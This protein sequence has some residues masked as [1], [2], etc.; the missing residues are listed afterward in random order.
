MLS[1]WAR[2]MLMG[3][4]RKHQPGKAAGESTSLGFMC[5]GHGQQKTHA[6]DNIAIQSPAA[7]DGAGLDHLVNHL[8]GSKRGCRA[9]E[10]GAAGPLLVSPQQDGQM[11]LT[12]LLDGCLAFLIM[13]SA[14]SPRSL[15]I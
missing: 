9:A 13:S 14:V 4:R 10:K 11:A 5:L 2:F 1:I 3:S 8:Q 7:V 6:E 12:T 15:N